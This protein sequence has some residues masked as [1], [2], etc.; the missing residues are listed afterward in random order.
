MRSLI[1]ST[2]ARFLLPLLLM[3]SIFLLLRGHN[4][5]G[6]GF[7][8]GLAAASAMSLYAFA[9]G[10]EK[11]RETLGISPRTLTASGLLVVL[12]SGLAGMV[13]AGRPFLTS[14]WMAHPI[15][16]I[17]KVGTPMMFDIGVY[18]VVFGI[19]LMIVFSLAEEG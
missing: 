12:L 10:A 2:T 16:V 7:V 3:F 5:P 1:L 4:E 14:L 8:G 9:F 18:M 17:G 6:G 13:F 15:P 11:V 19:T